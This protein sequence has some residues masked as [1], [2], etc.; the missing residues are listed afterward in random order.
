MAP[1][2]TSR[3]STD[4]GP[5]ARRGFRAVVRHLRHRRPSRS[6]ARS[7]FPRAWRSAPRWSQAAWAPGPSSGAG[8][9]WRRA[10][11]GAGIAARRARRFPPADGAL[12]AAIA[13]QQARASSRAWCTAR[14][15][16]P[17]GAPHRRRRDHPGR[18]PAVNR[19]GAA[20]AQR[21]RRVARLRP[22][23]AHPFLARLRPLRGLSNP[24]LPDPTLSLRG[25]GVDVLA[26]V[27][28]SLGDRGSAG[29]DR[30]ML[31]R[32]QGRPF[33][34]RRA[35]RT[36]IARRP[37]GDAAAF[38]Q[39]AVLAST[40]R[41]LGRGGLSQR[42]DQQRVSLGL[43]AAPGRGRCDLP[44]G[45]GAGAVSIPGLPRIFSVR[46]RLPPVCPAGRGLLRA[47]HGERWPRAL[48]ADDRVALAGVLVNRPRR[49]RRRWLGGLRAAAGFAAVA[50]GISLQLSGVGGRPIAALDRALG[51]R[52][53]RAVTV[54]AE[55]RFWFW[56]FGAATVSATA[57]TAPLG[58][59]PL[60]RDRA[61][62]RSATWC[63][64]AGRDGGG[65]VRLA[66]AALAAVMARG[67]MGPAAYRGLGRSPRAGAAARFE[68][69][70]PLWL[71]RSPAGSRR[72]VD[73]RRRAGAGR[74]RPRP[75]RAK[76]ALAGRRRDGAG[77]CDRQPGSPRA[78]ASRRSRSA[79]SPPRRGAGRRGSGSRR[80]AAARC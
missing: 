1:S 59:P 36:A 30:H 26:G 12:A 25:A 78:G 68:A 45:L 69:Y 16:R 56:R 71:S 37:G 5:I 74:R 28:E 33:R 65:S 39:T 38:L 70:A 24:G 42:P 44:V 53:T 62:R 75:A 9:R 11:P 76:A 80:L 52:G 49:R 21:S 32:A 64:S 4:L 19:A 48:G 2:L 14:R 66:G 43:G 47:A 73:R 13:S 72:G 54:G 27:G 23:R 20:R 6:S 41:A 40:R 35:M 51:P 67:R 18:W 8:R 50:A 29:A 22:W 55:S 61:G 3:N 57:V 46:T 34:A 77:G 10:V 7:R 58:A 60:R 17:W 63:W 79:A 15:S 31:T